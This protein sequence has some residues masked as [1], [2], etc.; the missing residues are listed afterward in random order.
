MIF[1]VVRG[2][3][4]KNILFGFLLLLPLSRSC[5][6]QAPSID[7]SAAVTHVPVKQGGSVT[8]VFTFTTAGSFKGTIGLVVSGLPNSIQTSWNSNPVKVGSGTGHSTLTITPSSTVAPNWYTFMVTATGDGVS[9]SYLF[10][11]EVEPASGMQVGLSSPAL[12]IEPQGNATM[13]VSATAI[14]GIALT[15]G[16]AGASAVITSHLPSHVTAEWS[17]PLV[18]GNS[19]SWTL[20]LSA[21]SAA[22]TGS[23][24]LNLSVQI[25]DVNSGLVYAASPGFPLLVSLLANVVVGTTPGGNIPANFL[26]LSHEWYDAQ[27]ILGDSQ[28]GIN[29][30][31]RQLLTNLSAYGS[32]PIELRIGGNSTDSSTEPVPTTVTPFAELSAAMGNHFILGVNLGADNVNLAVDQATN[33]AA[34]MPAGSLDAIE[35]GNEPDLYSVN[36]LRTSAYS[37]S[38]Y[39]QDF[40]VWSS[41]LLPLLPAGTLLAAPAGDYYTQVGANV[42]AYLANYAPSLSIFSEHFYAASPED[43]PA[44]DFLLTPGAARSVVLQPEFTAAVAAA[45]ANGLIFREDELGAISEQAVHG[46]SDAFGAALWSIDTMFELANAGV[47]GVNWEASDGNY[48]N[49]FSFKIGQSAGTAT[50]TL[51]SINPRYY[52]FLFFQ[53][54]TGG[55]AQLL[56]ATLATPANLKVWATIPN[57]SKPRVAIIN[58]DEVLAGTVRVTMPGYSRAQVIRLAAPSYTSL[59][60]ATFA[61]QTL[62]GSVDGT[63]QGTWTQQTISGTSGV[64][65]LSMP[66]TSAALVVFAE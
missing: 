26:G 48:E 55:G 17:A 4:L 10:T 39:Q 28:V 61:G 12:T 47:D 6:G 41:S 66:V 25:V 40:S 22:V 3:A 51:S 14:N 23:Y 16:A 65:S 37:F 19:V 11:V 18:N 21:T 29:T 1:R 57:G 42:N 5:H 56:P 24:A 34:S 50:Y 2:A 35:I 49:P 58:K 62:D 31:Y 54:A 46:I 64:F 38:D 33:F 30:I 43:N 32:G 9:L 63:L 45:H 13:T 60:G 20:T 44:S 27:S 8:D 53:A 59:T 15:A 7:F 36:G 52:G